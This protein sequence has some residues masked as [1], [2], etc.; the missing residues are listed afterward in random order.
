MKTVTTVDCYIN[1]FYLKN[2]FLA[3]I[4]AQNRKRSGQ[5]Q[6]LW[7]KGSQQRSTKTNANAA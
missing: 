4:G 2:I 5:T 7:K 3:T 1:V 6:T